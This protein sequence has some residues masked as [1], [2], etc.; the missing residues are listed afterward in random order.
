LIVSTTVNVE[1]AA[2]QVGYQNPSQFSRKYARM[3]GAP[4]R[5]DVA[6]LKSARWPDGDISPA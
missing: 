6:D 3:F 1:T 5:R 2:F 4:P